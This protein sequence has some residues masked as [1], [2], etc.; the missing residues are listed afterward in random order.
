MFEPSR[1]G[2]MKFRECFGYWQRPTCLPSS[3]LLCTVP[4]V[5]FTFYWIQS[6]ASS[7]WPSTLGIVHLHEIPH[8]KP[9]TKS[10]ISDISL[11]R[12]PQPSVIDDDYNCTPTFSQ[13][14]YDWLIIKNFWKVKRLIQFVNWESHFAANQHRHTIYLTELNDKSMTVRSL[15]NLSCLEIMTN[16]PASH[17]H[18]TEW[19]DLLL[20]RGA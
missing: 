2:N 10:L 3:S 12:L 17:F 8:P 4:T 15:P 18:R 9:S 16:C 6:F 1:C 20:L 11:Y 5:S 7:T 14:R 19:K 13:R